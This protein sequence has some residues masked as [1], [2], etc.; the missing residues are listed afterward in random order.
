MQRDVDKKWVELYLSNLDL[1]EEN[2]PGVMN[3][4]RSAALE[5]LNLSG[6]PTK[7]TGEGDRYHYTGL[8]E[9]FTGEYETYFTPSYPAVRPEPLALDGHRIGL[10]NGFYRG[11]QR[12]TI[13]ANGVIFGSLAEAAWQ[14]SDLI[15]G[16]YHTLAGESTRAATSLPTMFAQDGAFIYVPAGVREELPFVVQ[17]ALCGEGEAVA[18]FARHLFI[19]E[20]NSSASVILDYQTLGE[21]RLLGNHGRE[22]FLGEGASVECTELFR[23][24]GLSNMVTAGFARQQRQSRLHTLSVVLGGA[25]VCADQQVELAGPEA[26]NLT[27]GLLIPA[28]GEHFDLATDIRHAAPDCTSHQRIKGIAAGEGT[29]VFSGRIYVSPGAQ[30]TRAFQQNNNL[31]LSERARIYTKPQ[32]EI[33]A[34]DVKCSHG[35]T[36]GQ[37]D[38]EALYYMRQRGLSPEEARRLQLYGFAREVLDL[39]TEGLS[40]VLDSLAIDKID[41]L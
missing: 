23:L 8:R 13:L 40:G 36:V 29:S 32:L 6:L 12:L 22:I 20:E 24:N 30:R 10:V 16:Y 41:S 21:E 25:L 28:A 14:Y 38:A 33:Y 31:A 34:D 11:G 39:K 35:A 15:G 17:S 3:R 18:S 7:G 37:L 26:E 19:F 5:S 27:D 4:P 2:T 9:A 1:T